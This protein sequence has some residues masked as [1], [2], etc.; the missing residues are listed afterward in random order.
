MM[1]ALLPL[2]ALLAAAPADAGVHV[3]VSV[4][5]VNIVFDPWSPAYVPPPR[6]GWEWHPGYWDMWGTWHPGYWTPNEVRPGWIWVSGYWVGPRWVEGYWRPV[7]RPGYY[8]HDGYYA[9]GAWVPGSWV[10]WVEHERRE[11]AA[12][13][14]YD[15]YDRHEDRAD[16][17]EDVRDRREDYYDRLE[18]RYDRNPGDREDYYDRLEDRTDRAEDARDRRED[19]SDRRR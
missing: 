10:T 8:W 19:R 7:S 12:R 18:D 11:A 17:A 13:A 16:H 15:T 9:H 1:T 3:N 4:P 2:L 6:A 5:G 14:R